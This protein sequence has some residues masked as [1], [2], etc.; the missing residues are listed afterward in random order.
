MTANTLTAFYDQTPSGQS[1]Q[2]AMKSATSGPGG[3]QQIRRLEAKGS[4]FVTQKDQRVTGDT[5]IFDAKTNSITLSGGVVLTQGENILSADRLIV[6]MTT[7]NS[8]L[9]CDAGSSGCRV[10]ALIKTDGKGASNPLVPGS[11]SGNRQNT[12]PPANRAKSN[13]PTRLTPLTL[14][15]QACHQAEGKH[16]DPPSRAIIA[17]TPFSSAPR[18]AA[19]RLKA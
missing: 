19:I 15:H 5:G 13:E 3:S 12:A 18:A 14:A 17:T 8:R 4:V 10:R 1:K 2:P 16:G 9:E 11:A 6:D 7:G